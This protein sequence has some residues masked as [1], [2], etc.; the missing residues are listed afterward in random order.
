MAVSQFEIA[1]RGDAENAQLDFNASPAKEEYKRELASSLFQGVPDLNRVLAFTSKPLASPRRVSLSPASPNTPPSLR[2]LYSLNRDSPQTPKRPHRKIPQMAERILDAPDL[3]DD[4][5]LNLLDWNLDD[6]LVIALGSAVYLWNNADGSIVKLL[7][8]PPESSFDVTSVAW[9]PCSKQLLV[10][11][12]QATV[13]LWDTS[14]L[15]K[16]RSLEGHSARVG[17]LAWAGSNVCSSGSRNGELRHHDMRT[18]P[19]AVSVVKAHA[20]EVCGLK[21]S[22]GAS[23]S[24]TTGGARLASGG[25][26]NTLNIWDDRQLATPAFKITRHTAAVKA[27]AWAPWQRHLLAS[28]GGTADRMLRFWDASTGRCLNAVDTHSQVCAIQFSKHD[29]ELV[30]SHGFTHNQLIL[31]KYPSMVKLAELSGHTSRVLHMAQSPDGTTVASAG[32]DET[33]RFWK[34]FSGTAR[35]WD[36]EIDMREGVTG[37]RTIR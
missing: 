20:L 26:D 8:E 2:S 5:Y 23:I 13:E 27:L 29:R 11:T 31:W 14:T 24:N 28:G 34:V 18:P 10:G 35:K 33:L 17:S 25:N 9:S 30:S 16:I 4:Y 15:K 22:S 36:E 19:H 37:A 6:I 3:I 12:S 1:R 21:W 32:A 7:H